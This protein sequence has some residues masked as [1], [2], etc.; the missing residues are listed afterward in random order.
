MTHP[1]ERRPAAEAPS[2]SVPTTF[3]QRI[4]LLGRFAELDPVAASGRH[5]DFAERELF[6]ALLAEARCAA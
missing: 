3:E 5:L 1:Y 6:G 4:R 2:K